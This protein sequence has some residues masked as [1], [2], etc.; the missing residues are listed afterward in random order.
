MRLGVQQA[1]DEVWFSARRW[2]MTLVAEQAE[3][4]DRL[5]VERLRCESR[6][7]WRASGLQTRTSSSTC[8]CAVRTE[9]GE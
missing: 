3:D 4:G 9:N 8:D 1:G 6:A 7:E 2:K 5:A